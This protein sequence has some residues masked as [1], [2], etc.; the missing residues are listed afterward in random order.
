MATNDQMQSSQQ[1]LLERIRA[2]RIQFNL[3]GKIPNKHE[4]LSL[5]GKLNFHPNIINHQMAVMRRALKIAHNIVHAKVD[6]RLI[7]AGALLHDIGRFNSH[8]LIHTSMGGDI[9]RFLGFPEELARIAETHSMGG[10][11]PE[12]AVKLDLPARD[13]MPK[14]LEEKIVCLADKYLSGSNSVT[15]DERFK[16]WIE[17]YGENDF[18]KEQINRV[19]K[20]EEEILHLIH[21]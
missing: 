4:A 13:Y 3:V 9:L 2:N 10:L 1:E 14:T 16:R 18:L 19:K 7:R 11:T 6:L 20:L 15:I 12:E 8:E 21:D 17:K 5:L